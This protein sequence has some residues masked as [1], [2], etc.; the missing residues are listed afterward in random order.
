MTPSPFHYL[1]RY[2]ETNIVKRRLTDED[3]GD[4][5]KEGA[6]IFKIEGRTLWE[7][8]LDGPWVEID[9][10]PEILEGFGLSDMRHDVAERDAQI[11][12]GKLKQNRSG[13]WVKSK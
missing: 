10:D 13:Q 1:V 7:R 12:E 3:I 9:P 11:H 6:R 4:A 2:G 8:R 5:W